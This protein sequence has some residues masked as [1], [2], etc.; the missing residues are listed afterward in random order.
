MEGS[1]LYT[2]D[3]NLFY[4]RMI[5][6]PLLAGKTVEKSGNFSLVY[7]T[8]YDRNSNFIIPGLEGSSF[9]NS[10]LR[11]YTNMI[12]PKFSIGSDSYIG[13]IVTTRNIGQAHNYVASVDWS[14]KL[15]KNYY[16]T[17][18]YAFSDTRE[19]ND[20]TLNDQI[21]NHT[22][23]HSHYDAY[24]NGQKYNG[25]A[26]RVELDRRAKYYSFNLQFNNFSPTFQAQEGYFT[27]TDE[28]SIHMNHDF[29]YYPNNSF[30]DNGNIDANA[31]I[32]FDYSN[33]LMER[34][35]DLDLYNQ[36]KGQT[37]LNLNYLGVNEERFHN[38]FFKGV[39]RASVSVNSNA[40]NALSLYVH[41]ERGRYIY[42]SD[43]PSVGHGYSYSV[44]ATV[45]PTPRLNIDLSIDFSRLTSLSDDSVL[46]SG[47]ISRMKA[48]YN[49]TSRLFVRM[50]GQYDTF[51]HQLQIY[52]LVYY[53]L[54]PFTIFYAGMTDYM[55]K[56]EEPYGF[57]R[58]N[59]EFFVKFQYLIRS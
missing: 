40:L 17:G 14:F 20:T 38:I 48:T 15:L 53:K 28:R 13:G 11:A 24:F 23:G 7:L 51:A 47:D 12:R 39:R 10:N 42:R 36:F 18:Q 22:F 2:T 29:S 8:A 4:S 59:R 19:L 45:K 57:K 50:I 9:V 55:N 16:L 58:T 5:S 37:S 30:L 44:S 21:D 1:G 41:Y 46:Y 54:N 25:S 52:P 32:R 31:G 26:L 3:L 43:T 27:R 34:W 49:F 35:V 56:Y 33:R 6:D